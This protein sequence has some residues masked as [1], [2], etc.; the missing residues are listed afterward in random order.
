MPLLINLQL[1]LVMKLFLFVLQNIVQATNS[2]LNPMY[3]DQWNQIASSTGKG[4]ENVMEVYEDYLNVLMR[5]F[6]DTFTR[7]F[8]VAEKNIGIFY[9]HSYK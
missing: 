2:V 4:V 5:N 8:E 1:F 3:V 6:V 9:F 7:P